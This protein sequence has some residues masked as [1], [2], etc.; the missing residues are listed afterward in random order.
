MGENGIARSVTSRWSICGYGSRI[1]CNRVPTRIRWRVQVR[2][3]GPPSGA[4]GCADRAQAR[5][6]AAADPPGARREPLGQ[7]R[8]RAGLT[9]AGHA[10]LLGAAH[11][12]FGAPAGPA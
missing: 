10:R 8:A 11:Q 6:A 9:A 7:R 5:V 1:R 4:A 12:Q 3:G 2:A